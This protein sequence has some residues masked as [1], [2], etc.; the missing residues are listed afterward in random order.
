MVD[1]APAIPMYVPADNVFLDQ[2]IPLWVVIHK[3]AG[4]KSA[5]DVANFFATV[6]DKR[7]VH[8]VVGQDGTVVQCVDER[9]G[10]GGNCC[11]ETG[12]DS[13]WPTNINLNW[14]T[15]SVE[16]VDPAL[17]NSTPV[18]AAQKQASFLLVA[19]ICKR[20]G[21][22]ANRIVGHNSIAPQSRARCPGNYPMDELR[23]YVTTQLGGTQVPIGWTDDGT[24]LTAPN[25]I[26]VVQGFR[27]RVLQGWDP[28]N[29]PLEK[30]RNVD[31]VEQAD[32]SIGAGSIQT[33]TNTRL[34]WTSTKGIYEIPIGAEL[35]LAESKLPTP[36]QPDP[37]P[38]P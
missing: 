30:E 26:T 11:L 3:T 12:H 29:L 32:P 14:L 31:T 17:D 28:T 4:F 21:I 9:H 1:Y 33:F 36:D 25:G 38:V 19:D 16:H 20:H 18:T 2:N 37:N 6:P 27:A 5:Q 22:T 7:S 23:A 10:A 24:T 35:L 15:I 34:G 8:Y 13:F